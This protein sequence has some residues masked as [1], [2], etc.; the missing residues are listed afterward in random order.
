MTD[1]SSNN[2]GVQTEIVQLEKANVDLKTANELLER[3]VKFLQVTVA[4]LLA[5]CVGLRAGFA[6]SMAG[7]APQ[8]AL[9]SA[10]GLFFAVIMSS[11]VILTYI[12][13]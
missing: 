2:A 9:V 6:I 12:R 4:V 10:T 8:A 1:S 3:K 11:I 7:V 13:R 5:S